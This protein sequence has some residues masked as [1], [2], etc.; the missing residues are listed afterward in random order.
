MAPHSPY[1]DL[2]SLTIHLKALAEAGDWD[3]V[4][5][6]IAGLRPD[7]LPKARPSDRA[8]IEAALQNIAAINERAIPLRE[9]IARLLS[10]FGTPAR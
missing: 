3:T 7:Q 9:D 2:E 5:S 10:A 6:L 4:A 8:A 1:R